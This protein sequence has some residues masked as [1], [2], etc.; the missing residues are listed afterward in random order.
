MKLPKPLPLGLPEHGF[1]VA[2]ATSIGVTPAQL[3]HPRLAR[4]F[5][6]MRATEL[7][8]DL[9]AK[10]H[11]YAPNVRAN[12]AFSGLTAAVIWG[13]PTPSRWVAARHVPELV[14][15]KSAAR[16]RSDGL[17]PRRI[18]DSRFERVLHL[19]LPVVPP[20]LEFLTSCR[21]L[22]PIE[23]TMMAD[24]LLAEASH[25]PGLTIDDRPLVT[26]DELYA[27]L[28]T[29]RRTPGMSVLR[30]A[31][32]RMRAGV[33]SPMETRLRCKLADAGFDCLE[34][35]PEITLP[36]GTRFR[37][38]LGHR[39]SG[40]YLDYEGEHHWADDTTIRADLTRTRLLQSLGLRH[41]RLTKDDFEPAPWGSLVAELA[42]RLPRTNS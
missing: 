12:E 11:S 14:V 42:R 7:P 20:L 25:Y 36:D 37:A 8:G 5:H 6:G 24:A 22:G 41:I 19:G 40:T 38:D 39:E 21:D 26:E 17:K 33:E 34:I 4:P 13:L 9:L 23:A 16:A 29:W 35:Q 30:Q 31:V 3:R 18:L 28:K 15:P 32:E 27:A 2:A 10:C 1:T